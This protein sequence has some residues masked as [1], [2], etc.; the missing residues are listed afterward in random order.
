MSDSL[1]SDTIVFEHT[2]NEVQQACDNQR[3]LLNEMNI[4]Y[5]LNSLFV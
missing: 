1:I 3:K 5:E 4:P 2:E